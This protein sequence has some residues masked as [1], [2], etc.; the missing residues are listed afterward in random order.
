MTE[1]RWPARM[2]RLRQGPLA[3]SAP[4]AELW[5]DGGH[6]A[7]ASQAI[8]RHLAG[9]PKRATYLICGMLNT[10]DVRGYLAPLAPEVAALRAVS[11]PGESATLSAEE[12]AA[13]ARDVGMR[14]TE[15]STVEA[16]LAEIMNTDPAARVLICGS[17][18]LAGE[19]LRKNPQPD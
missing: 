13:A 2:Q 16:A 5:L 8:G 18:Y 14:A 11:I 1:A 7:A 6:N 9:L 3:D 12:T 4:R 15:A 17:L 10:K 19:V